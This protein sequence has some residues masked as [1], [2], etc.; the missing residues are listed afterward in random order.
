M[1]H[2]DPTGDRATGT[3]NREWNRMVR[4]AIRIRQNP[5][6]MNPGAEHAFTGIYRRLLTDPLE[7]LIRNGPGNKEETDACRRNVIP[8]SED[9]YP[10]HSRT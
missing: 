6:K 8:V 1:N 3:V 4:L 2:R 10:G 9:I 5:Q 7:E